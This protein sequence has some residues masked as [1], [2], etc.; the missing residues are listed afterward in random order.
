MTNATTNETIEILYREQFADGLVAYTIKVGAYNKEE[1]V[2]IRDGKAIGCTC[3]KQTFNQCQHQEALA[4]I[5]AEY[6]SH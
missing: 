6:Q 2:R 3:K 1:C 5:E 4:K